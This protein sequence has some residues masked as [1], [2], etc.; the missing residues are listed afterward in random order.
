MEYQGY[1][2]DWDEDRDDDVTKL[3]HYAIGPD[4]KRHDVDFTPYETMSIADF[5]TFIDLGLPDR[6]LFG[7]RGP[8]H[9][10]DL[11]KARDLMERL[12]AKIEDL[13]LLMKLDH[14]VT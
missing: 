10:D 1:R 4:G 7:G 5:R 12:S 3:W 13:P 14:S 11:T 6:R 2:Y 8:I 9:S